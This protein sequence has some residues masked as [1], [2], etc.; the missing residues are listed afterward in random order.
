MGA[1]MGFYWGCVAFWISGQ[2]ALSMRWGQK[3]RW[4]GEIRFLSFL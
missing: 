4:D 2:K 1:L 3:E